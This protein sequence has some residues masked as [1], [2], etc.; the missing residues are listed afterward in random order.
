MVFTGKDGRTTS[1][2]LSMTTVATGTNVRCGSK[3]SL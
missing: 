3:S 2:L 1:A